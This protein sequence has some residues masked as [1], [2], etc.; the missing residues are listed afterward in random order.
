MAKNA[1]AKDKEYTEIDTEIASCTQRLF[2]SIYGF[3]GKSTLLREALR[4]DKDGTP[5]LCVKL[6]VPGCGKSTFLLE[7]LQDVF[8]R[9][10]ERLA[11]RGPS[12]LLASVTNSQ[13]KNL[14][15]LARKAH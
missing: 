8:N 5:H 11:G 7:F 14:Y 9:K 15:M 1:Q 3:F 13:C 6:G 2:D 10:M 12:V 4:P